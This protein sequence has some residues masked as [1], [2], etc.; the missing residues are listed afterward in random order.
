MSLRAAGLAAVA[1]TAISVSGAFAA[2]ARTLTP[3]AAAGTQ[4][5]DASGS[6]IETLTGDPEPI[7]KCTPALRDCD[8][9]L[10]ELK[11]PGKLSVKVTGG[12]PSVLDVALDLHA[13]DASGKEGKQ[14]KHS[15]GSTP[16]VADEAVSGEFDPGFYL[17]RVDYLTGSGAVNVEATFAPGE[18]APAEPGT[19]PTAGVN[20]PP[21]TTIKLAKSYKASKLKGIGGTASDDTGVS[22][23]QVGL[24]LKGKGGKCTQLTAS[25]KFAKAKSC[26]APTVYLTATGTSGW[27]LKLKKQLAKGSYTAFAKAT[28]DKGLTQAKP[29]KASFKIK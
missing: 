21:T 8:D 3:F 17:I 23:V 27:A 15:D 7:P 11:A 29:A 4:K 13:S 18:A 20:A 14:L 6:G 9:T 19:T 22:K 25:G 10:V 26:N 24:L 2:P 1:V 12:D 16:Q 28:D 5:Y